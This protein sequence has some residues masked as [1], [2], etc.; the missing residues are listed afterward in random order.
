[1]ETIEE[2]NVINGRIQMVTEK[3]IGEY[4]CGF[5]PNRS[6]TDELFVI[7]QMMEKHYEHCMDLH[8]LFVDFRKAFGSVNRERIYEAMKQMEIPDKIIRLTRMNT[9]QAKIKID[10]KL[11]T[12]FEFN[13]G[14]KQGGGLSA[15]LFIV[16]LDN[17]IK[18]IDQ[19]GTIFTK[20]SQIC[21]YVD[22]IVIIARTRKNVIQIYKKMEDKT[23]KVGLGINESKTKYMIMSTSENRRK[24]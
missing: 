24:T 14:A 5:H 3:T 21:A 15:V 1:V 18:T 11:S 9:T 17:V 16:A 20:S 6:T 7:R 22:D 19:R 12:K 8:M 10:N 4:Q 23:R 13:F 2:S